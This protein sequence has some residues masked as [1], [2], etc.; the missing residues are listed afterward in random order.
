M[1]FCILSFVNVLYFDS[2]ICDLL[3]SVGVF[4]SLSVLIKRSIIPSTEWFLSGTVCT[5]MLRDF[6]KSITVCD[7][8]AGSSS[9]VS[10]RHLWLLIN[11]SN[12]FLIV[13]ACLFSI[14]I[15]TAN[16]LLVPMNRWKYLGS[17]LEELSNKPWN[18]LW[19]VHE[20]ILIW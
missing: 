10:F 13:L 11:C 5:C 7:I 4:I 1:S 2:C 18:H 19:C 15:A 12:E 20:N 16:L 9:D 3:L 14:G 17:P 8:N 6:K